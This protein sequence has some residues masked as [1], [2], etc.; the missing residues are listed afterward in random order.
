LDARYAI[1]REAGVVERVKTLVTIGT[2]HRGSPVADAIL[3][4]NALH[5]HIPDVILNR[6]PAETPALRDLTTDADQIHALPDGAGITYI[7]V[8]GNAARGHSAVLFRL[9]EAI[10]DITGEV[11]DGVVT[12]SS[13]LREINTHQHLHDWPVD[14]GGEVG[15]N[16][17]LP[18]PIVKIPFVPLL[19]SQDEHL[20]RYDDIMT[21]L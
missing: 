7:E 19:P 20:A 9:F 8:A 11:N 18:V 21:R 3:S 5:A 4:R 17:D 13:A 14:H 10:G 2:P 16:L 15:W 12:R 1:A 6:L